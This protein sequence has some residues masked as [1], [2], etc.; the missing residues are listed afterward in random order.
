MK[1]QGLKTFKFGRIEAR[2]RLPAFL[3]AWPDFNVTVNIHAGTYN[4]GVAFG[5]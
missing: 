3:G 4:V 1:T 5:G 2:M